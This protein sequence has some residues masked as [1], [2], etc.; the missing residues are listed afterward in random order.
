MTNKF[1]L[2]I[3]ITADPAR[4]K[5]GLAETRKDLLATYADAK[6][7]VAKLN[8]EL[9]DSRA[10]AA[11]MAKSMGTMGPPTRAMV[12][13][14][15]KMKASVNAAQAAVEKKS[16]ALQQSRLAIRENADAL[17]S[18]KSATD[19]IAAASQKAAAAASST[20]Q[21]AAA[22]ALIDAENRLQ[23][24]IR[25]TAAA[26][27]AAAAKAAA[28]AAALAARPLN[29]KNLA[30]AAGMSSL[31]GRE[32]SAI[33]AEIADTNRAL[34]SLRANGAAAQ[35]IA[36]ASQL[37]QAKIAA[38][39][40]ELNGVA[41]AANA[42]QNSIASA[43][44]RM[45]AMTAAALAAREAIQLLKS[46]VDTG[47]KFDSLKTQYQFGNGGDVRKAADEM[48][49]AAKLANR[50]GLE[51]TATTQGYGK[52]QAASKGT[53]LEGE[54]TRA[55]FTAI[56]SAS[57]VMGLS[58]ED[59]SGVLLAIS[60][61]MSKGTVSAE[62]LRG[63]LGERLPS[64]FKIAA[65]AMKVTEE[66]LGKMLETGQL[67]AAQFLPRFAEALQQSVNGSLRTAETSA[68]AN[69][70]RL[71][72]AFTEFK[73]RIASSGL[74]DKVSEQI[75]RL[76]AHIAAMAESGE[77]DKLAKGF[78]DAF[79]SVVK[80]LADAAIFAE[81]FSNVLGPLATALAAVMV[82][83]RALAVVTSATAGLAATGT[84]ATAASVG[85]GMLAAAFRLLRSMTIGGIVLLGVEKLI[86]WGAKANEARIHAEAL[87]ADIRKLIDANSEYASL[88][89][90]DADA[91]TEFGDAAYEAYEKAIKG[92]R[93]Y[94][95]AKVTDLV[96]TKER[97]TKLR[98][99]DDGSVDEAIAFYR[100]QAGAYNAYIDTVLAGEK[101]RREQV[102]LTGQIIAK[103]AEREKLLAGE[104]KQT[105]AEA[106]AD[107]IKGYE[108]LVDA[109]RKA[110]EESQKEA[111]EAKKKAEDLRSSAADKKMS[112]ADKATQI[113]EK[114]LTPEE[115]AA[116]DQARALDA[117]SQGA[118]Y[119]AAAAAAA[120][121]GRGKDFEKYAK[122]AEKFLERAMKFAES[123]QDANLV[124]EI[125]GQQANLDNS[126]AKVQDQKA[127]EAE[128]QAA[129]LMDQLNAAQAKL[130]E[131]KGE[132]ATVQ[133]NADIATAVTKLAEVEAKLNALN[134]K[135][136][137]VTV[138]TVSTAPADTSTMTRQELIDAIPARAYGGEIPGYAPH[139]RA[140][141]AL[142]WAT[143]GEHMMQIPA[144][145][146]YGRAFMD[147][148]NNMRIPRYAY[149]GQIGT[150]VASRISVPSLSSPGRSEP[151]MYGNFQING[152]DYQVQA[153]RSTFDDLASVLSREMLKKGRRS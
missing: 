140:D 18:V 115:R 21:L 7:A 125:G 117:Q 79:G 32:S 116:N 128:K 70:Q 130:K 24:E 45:A 144:V 97:L 13:D 34:A 83:G 8:A 1:A 12:A 153:P 124:E 11:E 67:T 76:L 40:A 146:Y 29:S 56:A 94:A 80:F 10:R 118:Y 101:L 16:L 114:D 103:E 123:A 69:L 102:R 141:N 35:D 22:Q 139:D 42:A 122:Q 92:A 148:I 135:S 31:G 46:S 88:T 129:A 60:Q 50:L 47:I 20:R 55:I 51:L 110:R 111:E 98:G 150:S 33:R 26:R 78:A 15:E 100:D 65:A 86:E 58:A 27:E 90:L 127:A 37:A 57:A 75:E 44:H 6:A 3:E 19:A 52:I 99:Y 87:Q 43:A 9:T 104:V 53:T 91:L 121:D 38:L 30:I 72:N 74:L 23:R 14:F 137:T 81:N 149:G 134:G 73:L 108:K 17:A 147:D 132:A 89:Q 61:M 136:A 143:P 119:A 71:E 41:P 95:S 82:G 106:I 85:I 84:A 68:R 133:V 96:A 49:Y 138:N 39:T 64:A 113:R 62:E 151:Q 120:L 77:L 63:Q 105:R 109:I 54:K 66:E 112:A 107:Q 152:R 126:K 2:G 5:A 142:I 93:D 4:A 25:E 131:L 28:E 145:R 59:Q 36:R 48:A